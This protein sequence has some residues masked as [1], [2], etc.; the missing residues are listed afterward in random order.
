MQK[1]LLAKEAWLDG[2]EIICVLTAFLDADGFLWARDLC[3]GVFDGVFLAL[4][5]LV[6]FFSISLSLTSS[7][8][9]PS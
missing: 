6:L 3:Y 1:E 4:P 9:E 5:F 7:I 2:L 8:A